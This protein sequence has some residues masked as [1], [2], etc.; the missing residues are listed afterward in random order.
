DGD[1]R[2]P[3]DGDRPDG[4]CRD[5]EQPVEDHDAA[6]LR[7]ARARLSRAAAGTGALVRRGAA[8]WSRH[9]MRA[10]R[11]RGGQP[12]GEARSLA[13]P[14]AGFE[15]TVHQLDEIARDRQPDAGAWNRVVAAESIERLEQVGE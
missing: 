6:A 4:D 3:C 15:R 5:R 7:G 12:Y 1:D 8:D 10:G 11:F 14:T 9:R 2:R 13:G